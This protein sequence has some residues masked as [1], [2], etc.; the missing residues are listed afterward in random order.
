[1]LVLHKTDVL[2][3]ILVFLSGYDDIVA[4]RERIVAEEKKLTEACKFTLYTLHSNMQ[5]RSGILRT[6]VCVI[7]IFLELVTYFGIV[8]H[9][10]LYSTANKSQWGVICCA[11][12]TSPKAHPAFHTLGIRLFLGLKWLEQD[13]NHLPPSAGLRIM[14]SHTSVSPLCLHKYFIGW[15][16]PLWNILLSLGSHTAFI[17]R[18]FFLS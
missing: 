9:D 5:V 13:A 8:T 6:L 12:Q 1:M 15:T 11:I 7:W 18:F 10:S 14:W 3:A 2:G 16:I 4:L 17:S